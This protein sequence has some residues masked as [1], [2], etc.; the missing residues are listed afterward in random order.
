MTFLG[1]VNNKEYKT[2]KHPTS[3]LPCF[4]FHKI[5]ESES[6]KIPAQ[7]IIQ[8]VKDF[9]MTDDLFIKTLSKMR[10]VPTLNK[11]SHYLFK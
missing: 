2:W 8:A 6:I 7:E 10:N 4:H 1:I 3:F 9:E 5:H 11:C